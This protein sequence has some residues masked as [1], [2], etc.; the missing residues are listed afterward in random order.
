M[1]GFLARFGGVP[2]NVGSGGG[3]QPLA[4]LRDDI[5]PR[6]AVNKINQ[7]L[8]KLGYKAFVQIQKEVNQKAIEMGVT[9]LLGPIMILL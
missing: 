1:Q 8:L 5:T 4:V 3:L 2:T 7:A 6:A 9:Y